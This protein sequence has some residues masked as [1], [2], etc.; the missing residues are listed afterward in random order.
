MGCVLPGRLRGYG[1]PGNGV[2]PLV[3]RDKT[4]GVLGRMPAHWCVRLDPGLCQPSGDW[5]W[6][7]GS[8]A[9]GPRDPT[10]G[11]LAHRWVGLEP[12]GSWVSVGSLVC[13]PCP[14]SSG[15]QGHVLGQL[16]A[17]GFLRQPACSWVGLCPYWA[18]CLA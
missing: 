7:L 15:G 2:Y 11:V 1:S 18:S 13:G 16:W 3:D 9:A 14:W 5:S 6:V 12:R 8:L 10:V 4:Q 17:Q